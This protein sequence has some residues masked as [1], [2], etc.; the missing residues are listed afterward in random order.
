LYSAS[1]RLSIQEIEDLTEGAIVLGCGGGGDPHVA[2][3]KVQQVLSQGKEYRLLEP[4]ALNHDAWVCILG[5]VGGGV[6][7]KEKALTENLP[8]IWESP[9][10]QVAKELSQYLQVE[11]DA[12]LCSE[13]GAGN[14]IANFFVAAM[15]GKPVVDGDAVGKQAKPEL[16]IS[17]TNLMGFPVTPLAAPTI[18]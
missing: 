18:S 3:D 13:I 11:F 4:E 14:T 10:I 2:R 8:R 5:N 15:E 6:E 17:L 7:P 9:I 12:Y 16:S 1:R